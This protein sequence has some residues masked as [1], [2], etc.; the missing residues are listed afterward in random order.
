MRRAA[1]QERPTREGI[2][3]P[4]PIYTETQPGRF[5]VEPWSTATNLLFLALVVYWAAKTRVRIR[6]HPLIVVGLPVL[7][8][9]FVG[10]TVYHATRSHPAWLMMDYIPIFVLLLMTTLY[11]WA[12][13]LNSVLLGSCIAMV[14]PFTL[15]P[16]IF[17]LI[18]SGTVPRH[19]GIS[20]AY[21]VQALAVV[22]PAVVHCL[23]RAR[24]HW[25]WLAAAVGCFVV[26]VVFRTIDTGLGARLL[27][28]GT[29]FLWHVFGAG[30]AGCVLEYVYRADLERMEEYQR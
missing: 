19:V 21:S 20:L 8:L 22:V 27:P 4:G 30:A 24:R 6:K 23:L 10:G 7:L 16:L 3:D 17:S 9:G 26:A 5:P 13:A 1:H 14:V 29:H 2:G 12:R 18:H 11:L 25:P 15:P 28:M